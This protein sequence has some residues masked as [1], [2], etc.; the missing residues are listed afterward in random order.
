M[1]ARGL[2][3]YLRS[4]K[5]DE[6]MRLIARFRLGNE[7]REG[8]YWESEDERACRICGRE[9]ESWEHVLERCVDGGNVHEREEVLKVLNESGKGY[10]WMKGLTE[11]RNEK[12]GR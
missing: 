1:R 12:M 10:E 3:R 11:Y 5:K 4:G 6:G 2:P 9:E 8:R 7:M